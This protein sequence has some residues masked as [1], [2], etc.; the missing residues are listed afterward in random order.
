MKKIN[1]LILLSFAVA[2]CPMY[3]Q[4]SFQKGSIVADFNGALGIYNT[5]TK[6]LTSQKTGADKAATRMLYFGGEYG[7]LNWLGVGVRM[8]MNSFIV[9]KDSS[10]TYHSNGTITDNYFTPSVKSYDFS[11]LANAHIIRTKKFDLA[12]GFLFGYSS[13]TF[14][15]NDPNNTIGK[16]GG[17]VFDIHLNPRLYFGKHFGMNLNIAYASYNYSSL[18][19]TSNSQSNPDK[20]SLGA[21][22]M[23]YSLGFQYR[24]SKFEK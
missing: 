1:S 2:T 9:S 18:S 13:L 10:Q 15:W 6:D 11:V 4:V 23:A 8:Q 22:G 14:T 16:G 24:F 5:Q 20:I 7:V 19:F 21:S 3:A 17:T 12:A